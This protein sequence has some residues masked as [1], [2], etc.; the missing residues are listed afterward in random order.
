M[1]RA[2]TIVSLLL[3][4]AGAHSCIDVPAEPGTVPVP[5]DHLRLYHYTSA[6]PAVLKSE[7]L[8]LSRS[9]GLTY[10]EPQF[11]WASLKQPGDHKTY[12]EFSVPIDD[13]RFSMFGARPDAHRGVEFYRGRSN[14]FT[15]AGDVSPSEFIAVHEPWH[16]HYRYMVENG[17]VAAVLAGEHDDLTA[18]RFPD[19]AKAVQAVKANFSA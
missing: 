3:E 7:G 19:E 12:V 8:L 9:K 10:G 15:L 1:T 2:S 16:R 13:P 14:D 4:T 18:D 6:D 11:V 5:S 17:F